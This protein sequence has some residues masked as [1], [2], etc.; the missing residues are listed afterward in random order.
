[1]PARYAVYVAPAPSTAL[2]A[3]GRQWLGRDVESGADLPPPACING[4]ADWWQTITRAPRRYGFHATMKPP[5]VLAPGRSRD[6]LHDA[7]RELAEATTAFAL[8]PLE[9]TEIG[10]F[11]ALV[12]GAPCDALTALA[13]DCVIELDSFRA[14]PSDAELARRRANSLTERQSLLLERWGYPYVLDEFRFHMTLTD[15]IADPAE[16]KRAILLLAEMFAPACREPLQ[17]DDLCLF[18]QPEPEMP[19]T[20]LERMPLGP[21]SS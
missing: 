2:A 5:F 8:P 11:L 13:D 7:L 3:L 12:P 18:L 6:E 4:A 21:V 10:S 15:G 19:F 1:M 9:L 14:P 20:L 16:R 17:V